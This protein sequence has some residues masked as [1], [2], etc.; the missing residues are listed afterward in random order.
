MPTATV[1]HNVRLPPAVHGLQQGVVVVTVAHVAWAGPASP[2]PPPPAVARLAWWGD[3]GAPVAFPLP[4]GSGGVSATAIF[5]VHCAA[6]QFT[7]YLADMR[8]L[9]LD[10]T[11]A[12]VLRT[13]VCSVI[14]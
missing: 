14:K 6:A 3:R 12:G 5:P 8:S 10:V 2:P 7:Q 1:R 11:D 13:I 9:V 4:A